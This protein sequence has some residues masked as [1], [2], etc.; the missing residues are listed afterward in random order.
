[1]IGE[2]AEKILRNE[3]GKCFELK[4]ESIGPPKL[5]LGGHMRKVKLQNGV[6]AWSFSSSQCVQTSVKNVE[7]HIKKRDWKLSNAN[8]PISTT[9]RPESDASDELNSEDSSYYQSLIGT[10][11]WMVELGR[12]DICLEV[13]MMSSHLALPREGHSE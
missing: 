13:S 10:L 1:M 11:R 3:I 7:D 2:E 8:T 6:D 4:E 5:Y 12:V 9:H